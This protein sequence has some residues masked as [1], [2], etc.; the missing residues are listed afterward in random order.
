MSNRN[1]FTPDPEYR[2]S[3]LYL[4]A[5]LQVAGVEMKKT[6]R[7]T[8]SGKIHFVFDTTI[9]SIEELKSAWF[10]CS[11]K[12]AANPYAASIKNLKSLVHSK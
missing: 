7:D 3:D 11:G 4:A 1:G 2:T 8:N 5:Y 10:N 12:V 9:A 6:E